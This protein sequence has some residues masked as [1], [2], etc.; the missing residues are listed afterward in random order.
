MFNIT[1]ESISTGILWAGYLTLGL[2]VVVV[3][4]SFISAED[5]WGNFFSEV[6]DGTPHLSRYVLL[7]GTVIVAIRFLV[8]VIGAGKDNMAERVD[9]AMRVYEWLDI[10]I[11]AGGSGAAYLMSK[12]TDGRILT[13]FGRKHS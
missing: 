6:T 8:A 7:F 13:L 12:V 11:L 9:A 4:R 5:E 1:I 10:D 2:I 3:A